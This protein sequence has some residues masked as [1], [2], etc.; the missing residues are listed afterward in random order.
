MIL[1]KVKKFKLKKTR[2]IIKIKFLSYKSY[3]SRVK[4]RDTSYISL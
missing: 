2:D 3:E 1:F 4:K